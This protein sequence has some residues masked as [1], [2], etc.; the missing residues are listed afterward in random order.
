VNA[1]VSDLEAF[2]GGGTL[3]DDQTLMVLKF[4]PSVS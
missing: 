2:G 4:N 3:F 1:C